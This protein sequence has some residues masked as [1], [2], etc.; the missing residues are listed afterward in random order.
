[1]LSDKR[2]VIVCGHYG[3]GKT[4]FSLNLALEYAKKGEKVTL[5]DLDLVNP[6]F[7]S[8]DKEYRGIMDEYSIRVIAP[9]YAGTTVDIPTLPPEIYSIFEKD[10]GRIV[11]DVGGDSVG[12][13]VLGRF[14]EKLKDEDYEMLY[15]INRFRTLVSTAQ[16]AYELLDE[17]Q[18]VS[19]LRATGFVNNSHLMDSTSLETLKQGIEYAEQFRE[20]SG[21]DYKCNTIPRQLMDSAL[22]DDKSIKN[23]FPIEI[24]VKKP[25]E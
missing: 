5:V 16:E 17:I 2:I 11:I 4:N 20:L 7:R 9:T 13:T 18:V 21:L 19:R 15:V 22:T 12:S 23:L 14:Y 1:M 24:L 3:C 25:W 10:S 8:S 6:Y